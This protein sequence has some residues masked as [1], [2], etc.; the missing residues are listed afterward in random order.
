MMMLICGHEDRCW[1]GGMWSVVLR[2]IVRE[3]DVC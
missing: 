1:H 3:I 2:E